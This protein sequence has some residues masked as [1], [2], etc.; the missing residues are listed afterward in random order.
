MSSVQGGAQ[1]SG[2]QSSCVNLGHSLRLSEPQ[3]LHCHLGKSERFQPFWAGER[4]SLAHKE[5]AL[6]AEQPGQAQT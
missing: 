6:S 4:I 1:Q 3:F 5:S 2:A